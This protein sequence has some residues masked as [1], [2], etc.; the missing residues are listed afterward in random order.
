MSDT[1]FLAGKDVFTGSGASASVSNAGK[2]TITNGGDAVLVGGSVGN[3]G[4]GTITAD[5]GR[6]GLAAGEQ[7]AVDVEGDGFLTVSVPGTGTSADALI[8]SAGQIRANGG[9][10]E[11]RAATSADLARAAINIDGAIEAKS[12]AQGHGGAVSFGSVTLDGGAG[13]KVHVG[14]AVTVAGRK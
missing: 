2:I 14:G 8:R 11:A 4:T 1:N 6:V 7:V 13:G 9:T 3:T 10:V 12:V 5:G